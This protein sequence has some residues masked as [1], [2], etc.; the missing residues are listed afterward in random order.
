MKV[1]LDLD[2]L[3]REQRITQEEYTKLQG[4]AAAETG[5]LAL[6][7]VLGFGVIATAGGALAL[8][9][10]AG[11]SI[12]LGAL[13]AFAGISITERSPRTW[14]VLGATL[15]LVGALLTGGGIIY[16]TQGRP[17]GFLVVTALAAFAGVAA[18]SGLLVS[19]ATLCLSAAVGA[20][21]SYGH[22]SYTLIIDQPALTV[23]LFTLVSWGLYRVSLQLEPELQRL[24]VIA[25]RTALF[26]VN[27]GFWVGSLWGDSPGR[28]RDFGRFGTG[29][30]IPAGVFAAAWAVALIATGTWAARENRRWVVNLVAVFGAIHFYTQY[31]E[32]LGASPGS[33]IAAGLA[34]I[35][36]AM[37]LVRYNRGNLGSP[38]SPA[39][40]SQG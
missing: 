4:F 39:F 1:T 21:T 26:L 19:A 33:I 14:G 12:V 5:S 23:L 22:A 2:K 7:I 30:T 36:I 40:S 6:N 34:A 9:Q 17:G 25:S 8:L 38:G 3:R 24:A 31:F 10:S 18:R 15:L 20:T 35:A 13:L 28:E 29:E 16:Y 11:A 32:R 37:V 27:F